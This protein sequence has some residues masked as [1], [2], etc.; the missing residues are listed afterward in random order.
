MRE[1]VSMSVCSRVYVSV[2][3]FES[4]CEH[5]RMF[6]SYVSMSVFESV[7][8]SVR[9]CVSMRVCS[10]VYVRVSVCVRV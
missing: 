5:E 4:V 2:S 9:E 7:S 1:C 3:V 8:V 6:E 10:R